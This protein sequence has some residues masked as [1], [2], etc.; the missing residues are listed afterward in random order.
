MVSDLDGSGSNPFDRVLREDL[1]SPQYLTP[2]EVQGGWREL[3]PALAA[4]LP[5]PYPIFGRDEERIVTWGYPVL[6]SGGIQQL[7]RELERLVHVEVEHRRAGAGRQG[8]VQVTAQR[9]R[10]QQGLATVFGNTLVNDY[11]RG[12]VEVFLLFHSC[13]VNRALGQ[14]PKLMRLADAAVARPAI[15][16]ARQAIAGVLAD[17]LQRSA[18]GAA[19]EL[20]R[21][22]EGPAPPRPSPLLGELC[23]DQLLLAESRP[24]TELAQLDGYLRLRYRQDARGVGATLDQVARRLRDLLLRQ[25][26]L[27]E[28]LQHSTGSAIE[29]GAGRALLEPRLL[30]ALEASGLAEAIGLSQMLIELLSGLGL[31]LK[32]FEL[33]AALRSRVLPMERQASQLVLAG[34]SSATPIAPTT[35]PFDFASP[36][37]VESS[38]ERF[39]LIYDLTNFT[40][41]LEGVRK[42]GVRA[43]ERALQLMFVFQ[44]QLEQI[45]RRRRLSFE[46][47][48]GDGAF[49]SS[50]RALRVIA[51]ACEIQRAYDRLRE[52]GFSF[53]QGIRLAMNFGSY[54]LLPMLAGGDGR[55]RFE[56]FGHG[57]VELVRLTTGKSTREVEEIAEFLIHSGYD[58]AQVDAFL[59]PIISARGGG[60]RSSQRRYSASLDGRG[61]LVNEGMVLTVGFLGQLESELEL[62]SVALVEADGS[63]WLVFP[64]DPGMPDTLYVGLRFLGVARL[65]GLAPMELV[66][67]AVWPE[68]PA[69]AEVVEV[70]GPL[71]ELLR[72]LAQTPEA[73][74][75]ETPPE[76]L[77]PEHLVVVT[78]TEGDERRWVFGEYR[79]SDDVLLHAIQV[80]LQAPQLG[81]DEP[82]EMWL[83][84]NRARLARLYLGFRRETS[85]MS[86]PLST[87]R[88][89]DDQVACFL[90]A[91]H[92]A[93][94]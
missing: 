69:E 79:D 81:P 57:L 83:F 88:G 13:D 12:L 30:D 92:R 36:G 9:A 11:G 54:H 49:Y 6:V 67:A 5:A 87:L 37:V 77:I 61:E 91:P 27:R 86:I 84:R 35:R 41:L 40:A 68:S 56:F 16:D 48:L 32:V 64:I 33:V 58:G 70:T 53:D 90:A 38:V 52:V 51:A 42:A 15:E 28:L 62:A 24:P 74:A 23:R 10:Y 34:P 39:G 71:L 82:V 66:E 31:R 2:E 22:A 17:L 94:G 73:S 29:P 3:F 19:D 72:R 21:L 85:G 8:K 1:R 7:R 93:P 89:R 55:H 46:K 65:K 76:G 50:R 20:R 60:T 18:H 75:P 59:A 78:Y 47:F 63:R 43:E 80:P 45:R 25:P 26:E 44:G 14:V 4:C